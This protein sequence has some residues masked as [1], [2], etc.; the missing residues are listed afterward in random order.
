MTNENLHNSG[1]DSDEVHPAHHRHSAGTLCVPDR[2]RELT[3]LLSR[4]A[5][6]LAQ[7][8][9]V[10]HGPDRNSEDA[11]ETDLRLD[12][13]DVA[14]EYDAIVPGDAAA[15]GLMTRITSQDP[16]SRMPP[17][18]HGR[19]IVQRRSRMCCAAGFRPMRF[20]NRTGRFANS[21]RHQ[22]PKAN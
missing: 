2:K 12:L 1:G 22:V 14:L 21:G 13:R 6:V 17:P 11:K 18:D 15:S 20:M 3:R 16:D 4:R 9:F 8:C 10:C 5:I 19:T 7:K